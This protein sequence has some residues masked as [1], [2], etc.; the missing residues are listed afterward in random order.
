MRWCFGL[1]IIPS[2]M[3]TTTIT[4]QDLDRSGS[5]HVIMAKMLPCCILCSS[6]FSQLLSLR[7]LHFL[8]VCVCGFSLWFVQSLH[9]IPAITSI[10][11]SS[12][13]LPSATIPCIPRDSK[14]H[15]NYNRIVHC[16]CVQT[17]AKSKKPVANASGK[18]TTRSVAM[19][20]SGVLC[21]SNSKFQP[22]LCWMGCFIFA[23]WWEGE[24]KWEKQRGGVGGAKRKS[25]SWWTVP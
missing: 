8:C 25:G 24:R 21:P 19:W 5:K 11:D 12:T 6:H 13:I 3:H 16:S 9:F 20:N 17:N 4:I 2:A 18:V 22:N 23:I 15:T 14:Y 1:F 10:V 7:L